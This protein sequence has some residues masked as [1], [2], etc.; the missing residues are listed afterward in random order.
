MNSIKN[1]KVGDLFYTQI[2][3][4]F[5]FM[6]IIHITTNLPSP[7][8][9]GQYNY[10]YFMAV[11]EKS[12]SKLPQTIE[13]LDLNRV[14][15]IKSKPK[16]AI[17]Y[18]SHWNEI[19]E[20]KVKDGRIDSAKH[21]KYK[22]VYFGNTY[23]TNKFEPVI[24]REFTLPS[25]NISDEKGFT[26]S[27]SPDDINW[28]YSRLIQDEEKQNEKT[29]EILPKYFNEWL[30]YVEADAIIKTEKILTSFELDSQTKDTRKALKKCIVALN[31]LNEKL[32]FITT[33]EAE[34]LVDQIIKLSISFGLNDLESNEI[35]DK[36]RDW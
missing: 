10:G 4:K 11:F 29:K 35:I 33:I 8:N 31:K 27:H 2:N 34:S 14:Y 21:K 30:E 18:V 15:Q 5:F 3:R 1:P 12:F 7:Y 23:V 36:N 28:I 17:L 24:L 26:I 32:Q 6:Q 9:N 19:P 25:R 16:K 13:E 22:F 20:I